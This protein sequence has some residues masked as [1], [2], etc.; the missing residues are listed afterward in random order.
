[1]WLSGSNRQSDSLRFTRDLHWPALYACSP[2]SVKAYGSCGVL[3]IYTELSAKPPGVKESYE[4][5]CSLQSLQQIICLEATIFTVMKRSIFCSR[6][7]YTNVS[8]QHWSTITGK[9]EGSFKVHMQLNWKTS[10]IK[11]IHSLATAHQGQNKRF[12]CRTS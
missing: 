8:H 4:T 11:R 10:G 2:P 7:V 5:V 9:E 12:S 6:I 1:M 3:G